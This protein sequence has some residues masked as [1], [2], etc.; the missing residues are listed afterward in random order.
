M[1]KARDEGQGPGAAVIATQIE[2]FLLCSR[3][4]ERFALVPSRNP[5]DAKRKHP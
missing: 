1:P 5:K 2:Q 4:R 3:E